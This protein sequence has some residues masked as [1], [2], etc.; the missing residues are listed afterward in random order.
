MAYY[1]KKII[2]LRVIQYDM[3]GQNIAIER[4]TG[5]IVK[6][7]KLP[8]KK[9]EQ[10]PESFIIKK[11]EPEYPYIPPRLARTRNA[12]QIERKFA[13]LIEQSNCR[14]ENITYKDLRS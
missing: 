4:K 1:K 11:K 3:F 14:Y 7:R 8:E 12:E 2:K 9:K 6:L 5:K 10:A 13:Q